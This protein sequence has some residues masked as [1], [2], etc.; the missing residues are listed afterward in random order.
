MDFFTLTLAIPVISGLLL[1]VIGERDWAP[2]LNIVASLGTFLSSAMLTAEIVAAGS[3]F[4]F[5]RDVF[6]RLAQRLFRCPDGFR[7]P[8]HQHLLRAL[9]EKRAR[10]RKAYR[11]APA[12][13]QE[14]VPALHVHHAGGADDQQ[15][16]HALGHDGGGN[17]DYGASG[18]AL[19]HAGQ[20]RG[21]LEVFHSLRRRHRTGAVRHH[22]A[23]F[24]RRKR[25]GGDWKCTVVDPTWSM[26][27]SSSTRR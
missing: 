4:R 24:R 17:A 15:H 5:R 22:P 25:A 7:R 21:G 6:H 3:A 19:P 14:H 18:V 16:G 26:S 1:T 23:L 20:P 27:R 11:I 2:N 13:L 10:A 9:H 8:Y 12:S